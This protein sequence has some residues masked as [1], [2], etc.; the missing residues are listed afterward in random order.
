MNEVVWADRPHEVLTNGHPEMSGVQSVRHIAT[1]SQD[2]AMVG[3]FFQRP[4]TDPDFQNYTGKN[5]RWALGDDS[6]LEVSN[7]KQF[8]VLDLIINVFY[9][10][11]YVCVRFISVNRLHV[12]YVIKYT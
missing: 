5:S 11:I 10:D 9:I 7:F 8:I 12:F 6:V 3:Y 4:Q 2:D 1:R